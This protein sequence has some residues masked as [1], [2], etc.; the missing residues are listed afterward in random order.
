VT[1]ATRPSTGF[2]PDASTPAH[3]DASGAW[4]RQSRP[5]CFR[6]WWSCTQGHQGVAALASTCA[7]AAR[8]WRA[9]RR[10]DA[11]TQAI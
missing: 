7:F 4:S 2:S 5:S 3:R 11:R 6:G 10:T 8:Q 1:P 9:D